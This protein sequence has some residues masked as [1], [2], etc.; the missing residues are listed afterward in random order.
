MPIF[1]SDESLDILKEKGLLPIQCGMSFQAQDHAGVK[2]SA[3]VVVEIQ[4]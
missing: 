4:L 2:K 3:R 1:R